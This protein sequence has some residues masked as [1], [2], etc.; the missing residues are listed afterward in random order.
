MLSIV[1]SLL[2]NPSLVA[3]VLCQVFAMSSMTL[4]LSVGGT[5]GQELGGTLEL[6][7]LP[8]TAQVVGTFLFLFPASYLA[9]AFGRKNSFLIGA[10]C[11]AAGSIVA[12]IAFVFASFP[13]FCAG[14]LLI[15]FQ[16]A[17]AQYFRFAAVEVTEQN[18]HANA[19]SWVL[20]GGVLA[21]FIGP[22]LASSTE[23]MLDNRFAG[24]SLGLL[25]LCVL[26]IV[27]LLVLYK[28]PVPS[29]DTQ[30]QTA[31]TEHES[32]YRFAL[33][34]AVI[35]AA[36]GF[37]IMTIL[38]NAAP[39]AMQYQHNMEFNHAAEAIRWHIFAM[40]FPSF[41]TG[42]LIDRF[43][44]HIIIFFGG[45]A[46]L[47]SLLV[48]AIDD[49]YFNFITALVLL[50]L[51]WNFTYLGG[52]YLLSKNTPV[53]NKAFIQ[54][55]NDTIV[56]SVNSI[57]SAMAGVALA[58]VGWVYLNIAVLPV[59]IVVMLLTIIHGIQ[60]KKKNMLD[61]SGRT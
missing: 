25:V 36:C 42:R 55:V 38:M 3:L 50:G 40:Y 44:V 53:D 61:D 19:M 27:V 58:T 35:V 6:A 24:S 45:V 60:K 1:L 14:M 34:V 47:L 52:S 23:F 32:S 7:T 22:W 30:Q 51:G 31:V 13:L 9:K 18:H 2:K 39:V 46:L 4:V 26:Q 56:F 48:A 11:G 54:G 17:S 16:N 33:I 41:F 49:S 59:I 28:E 29:Y 21:A 12:Y 8:I 57:A 5:I 15:G 10:T 37:G 43:G 20:A